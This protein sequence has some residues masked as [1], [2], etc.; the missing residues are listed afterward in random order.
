MTGG[1]GVGT[2]ARTRTAAPD[3]QLPAPCEHHHEKKRNRTVNAN[4]LTDGMSQQER[5]QSLSPLALWAFRNRKE[6]TLNCRDTFGN[7]RERIVY[8][9]KAACTYKYWADAWV[10]T[11]GVFDAGTDELEVIVPKAVQR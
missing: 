5:T 6:W 10:P 9:R 7:G 3:V 4:N 11:P 8:L 1:N 2:A